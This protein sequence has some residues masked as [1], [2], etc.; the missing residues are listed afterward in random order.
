MSEFITKDTTLESNKVDRYEL[1]FYNKKI[2]ELFEYIGSDEY[3][4]DIPCD[5]K[6]IR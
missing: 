5:V 1:L 2:T 3:L 6:S 4:N